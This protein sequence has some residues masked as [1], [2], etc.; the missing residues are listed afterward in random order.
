MPD[1]PIIFSRS[2]RN[3]HL[4]TP[5]DLKYIYHLQRVWANTAGFLT[6]HTHRN[7]VRD[8]RCLMIDQNNAPAGYINWHLSRRGSVTM[9]QICIDEDL[10]RTYLGTDILRYLSAAAHKGHCSIIRGTCRIDVP[11][12]H[13][14]PTTGFIPTAFYNPPT[15]RALPSIEWTL[16]LVDPTPI[17]DAIHQPLNTY[18]RDRKRPPPSIILP[19]Q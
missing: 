19:Q 6:R 3:V 4:A 14:L 9:H 10:L 18:T 16:Y 5:R 1:Q 13:V 17:Y 15:A 2:D 11:A 8:K 7:I 12:T